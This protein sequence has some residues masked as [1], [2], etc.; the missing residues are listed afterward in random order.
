[1]RWASLIINGIEIPHEEQ[2]GL[3]FEADYNSGKG[4]EIGSIK[5]RIY[6]LSQEI[7]IGSV[8]SYDFGRGDYGGRF[9]TFTVK[10][11]NV[12]LQGADSVQEVLCS[13]RAVESSN[14]VAVSL[15]GEI[16]SSQAIREICKNAGLYATQIELK[17]DK[18]YPTSY[19]CFGKAIDELKK[20]AN[21]CSSKIKIE[22]KDV[23]F[24]IEKPSQKSIIELSFDSGLI[25]N[26][27]IS[28]K[29]T[30]DD[31]S[32]LMAQNGEVQADYNSNDN[33]KSQLTNEF[34]YSLECLSIHTLKKGNMISI[35]GTK[36]FNGLAKIHSLTMVNSE[37]WKMKLNIK[38]L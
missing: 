8:I 14:I 35:K 32:E 25:T 37:S 11:R 6:N 31:E 19:S 38:K 24:Y 27:M 16:K 2:G 3:Y 23:Y 7:K 20:I 13:E 29:L 36:T 30:S 4:N 18:I 22:N 17:E 5:F 9:G 15:K 21:N 10:K 26:P 12:Y 34:D 33:L 28:E 1:M